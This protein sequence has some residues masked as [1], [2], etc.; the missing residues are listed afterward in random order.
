LVNEKV[1]DVSLQ[2]EIILSQGR[3]ILTKKA[4]DMIISL[5]KITM[6]LKWDNFRNEPDRD[7]AFQTG[8]YYALKA[9]TSCDISSGRK[10]NPYFVECFKRGIW[11]YIQFE[12]KYKEYSNIISYS[13]IW[14]V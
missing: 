11:H 13:N 6:K 14:N 8:V 4:E 9:Y 2:Y 12:A 1:D 10:A 3:G 5:C 7:D